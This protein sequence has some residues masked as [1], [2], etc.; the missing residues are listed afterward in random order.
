MRHSVRGVLSLIVIFVLVLGLCVPAFAVDGVN[1]VKGDYTVYLDQKSKPY[2]GWTITVPLATWDGGTNYNIASKNITITSGSAQAA[3]VKFNESREALKNEY[4]ENGSAYYTGKAYRG[5][6]SVTL[7][8][9]SPGVAV[10]RYTLGGVDYSIIVHVL[11]YQNPVK[12]LKLTGVNSNKSFAGLTGNS[13]YP[14]KDKVLNAT[15]KSAKLNV[16]AKDG[17]K[18]YAVNMEDQT[19]GR[20]HRVYNYNKG[21]SSLTMTWGTLYVK[22]WY[23]ITVDLV[24]TSNGAQMQTS[25]TVRG[26]KAT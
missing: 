26:A 24:N 6:C 1:P 14:T 8:V 13:S 11:A 12:T 23:Y 17:W 18:I 9:Q 25:Y 16:A 20:G 4:H 7:C 19:T 21:M 22:H 3:M 5:S 2:G 10:I 15:T